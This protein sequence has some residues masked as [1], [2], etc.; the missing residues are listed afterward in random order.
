[1]TSEAVQLRRC[2]CGAIHFVV[3]LKV[4]VKKCGLKCGALFME[5]GAKVVGR[6]EPRYVG[7]F[8]V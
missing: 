3:F 7:Q 1:M 5:L 6:K 4:N 2:S 8:N